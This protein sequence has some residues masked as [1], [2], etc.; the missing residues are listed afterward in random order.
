MLELEYGHDVHCTGDNLADKVVTLGNDAG[1]YGLRAIALNGL[2]GNVMT[3]EN[4]DH[5]QLRY[6][7]YCF[8]LGN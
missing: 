5:N 6:V 2:R 3:I 8:S 4:V 1:S 7:E